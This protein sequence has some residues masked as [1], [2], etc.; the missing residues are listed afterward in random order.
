[1][2]PAISRRSFIR[3]TGTA[4]L[5]IPFIPDPSGMIWSMD[6][7]RTGGLPQVPYGAVYFRKSN[8][9]REDWERDYRTASE[10]GINVFRHW[11]IWS[12]IETS[13]GV[14][15]WS[16]Y[17]R[18]MELG[19]KYG[20]RTVIAEMSSLPPQWVFDR[21]PEVLYVDERGGRPLSGISPATATGG[22]AKDNA[23]AICLNTSAGR[24]LMGSFL[25]ALAERYKDHPSLMAYDVWNEC[26]YPPDICY[27]EATRQSFIDW[28]KAKYGSVDALKLAW[29]RYSLNDWQQ[30]RIPRINWPWPECQDWQYFRK[31][32]F[33]GHMQWR[34]DR[35][36]EVDRK[37][38]I[39]A[40]GIG[41]SINWV[42]S[43]GSD[44]WEAAS[45]VQSYGFTFVQTR[46]GNDPVTLWHSADLVRSG[47]RGK[48]FWHSE[49]QGGP[50]W[51]ASMIGR[52]VEDGRIAE[53]D[54]IRIWNMITFAAGGRGILYPRW[55]PLLDGPLHGAFGPYNMDGSRNER[56]REMSRIARWAN[57]PGNRSL[58][59]ATPVKGDLGILFL[60]ECASYSYL[61]EDVKGGDWYPKALWG[62]CRGFINNNIQA[63]WV[64]PDDMDDYDILY[65]PFPLAISPEHAQKLTDW[66]Q[67]GGFLISEG[68]P[69]YFGGSL[70]AG[71][72]Q[73][74]LGMD[75]LFGAKESNVEFMPDIDTPFRMEGS[76]AG[77]TG[78]GYRQVYR[79]ERGKAIG[80]Y[81]D[82]SLA[83]VLNSSGKGKALLIG[84]HPSIHC[85]RN[86]GGENNLFFRDVFKLT[87]KE[88]W[89]VLS[90]S[91]LQARLHRSA[92]KAFLWLVNPGRKDV[93]TNVRIA[94][95]LGDLKS[96]SAL[97]NEC[98]EP[99]VNN[100]F[101]ASIPARDALI[102]ELEFNNH[103]HT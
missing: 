97:W 33:Y 55:R 16:D 98:K 22:Y 48:P 73:P 10:D 60:H 75:R 52:E 32:N 82:G 76:D 94:R 83:A 96:I 77:F 38:L 91:N 1:M 18:Q 66:V 53:P 84:T 45:H 57:D 81:E 11:F 85:H 28:L 63:D 24:Q 30:V 12:A 31:E 70:H 50:S 62:A 102:L 20:I 71:E 68:C 8:P 80:W 26:F 17:D 29:R 25:A 15:D 34:I 65:L 40:H 59:E 13:P 46:E 90:N 86:K 36:R 14:Y 87:G 88:Q 6:P 103:K 69:G 37:V 58:F 54:D 5:L 43:H 35:I 72:H 9:P 23:G 56:S 39:T 78:G 89:V 51:F 67:R 21:Y 42:Y 95:R 79:T 49:A 19:E 101:K 74:N 3:S 44:H 47:S 99:T 7:D 41:N 93:E 61:S 92:E 64:H 100:V 2:K 27:H 4:S